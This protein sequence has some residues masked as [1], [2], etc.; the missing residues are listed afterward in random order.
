MILKAIEKIKNVVVASPLIDRLPEKFLEK[1]SMEYGLVTIGRYSELPNLPPI[2]KMQF[3]K[4]KQFGNKYTIWQTPN[5]KKL[6]PAK[7]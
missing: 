7:R 6:Y 5:S 1:L 3:A 2:E 4:T